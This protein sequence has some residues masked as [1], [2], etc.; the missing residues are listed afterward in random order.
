MASPGSKIKV[1]Q[2]GFPLTPGSF[3]FNKKKHVI[4]NILHQ[5]QEYGFDP[6]DTKRDWSTRR[7][8]KYFHVQTKDERVFEIFQDITNHKLDIWFLTR[9]IVDDKA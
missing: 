8:R 6:D 7:S 1:K 3:F 5:W 2:K 9:E 4:N